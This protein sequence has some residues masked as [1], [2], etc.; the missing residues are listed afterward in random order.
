MDGNEL[1][2]MQAPIKQRYKDDPQAAVVTLKA[3]GTLDDANIA[4][5]LETGRALA[6][7]GPASGDRRLRPRTVLGRHA[8]GGAGRLRRRHA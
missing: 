6:R 8:A 3:K 4:C 7:R 2:A 1:R 5:K